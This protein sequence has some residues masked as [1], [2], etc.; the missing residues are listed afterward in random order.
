MAKEWYKYICF[1]IYTF[2]TRGQYNEQNYKAKNFLIYKKK[3]FFQ[4]WL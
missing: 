3:Y 2:N 1:I 4:I